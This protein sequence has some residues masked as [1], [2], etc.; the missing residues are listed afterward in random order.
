MSHKGESESAE[1]TAAT[2]AGNDGVGLFTG[3]LHL[4]LGLQTDD[5]LMQRDMVHHGAE[6]IFAARRGSSQFDGLGDSRAE[7]ARMVRLTGDDIFAGAGG[8]RRRTGDSSAE[9]AHDRTA[10]GLL[11]HRYLH[12]INGALKTKSL[13]RITECRAPLTGAGLCGDIRHA[14]L[15][16][17]VTLRNGGVELVRT[18]R[19]DTLVL[20]I[21][22]GGGAECFLQ[23]IGAHERRGAVVAVTAQHLFWDI[24][25]GVLR[26][27]FLLGALAGK[28]MRQVISR[29]R[30]AGLRI[31]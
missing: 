27:Q 21:D 12:L 13:G 10:V 1:V 17:V 11:L 14:F 25:P 26:V 19:V 7:R 28:Q 3:H 24:Y 4:F 9:S 18:Q 29:K 15:L 23:L 22:M 8:H 6:R 20:E 30:L 16:A 31:Q 2:E 5:G